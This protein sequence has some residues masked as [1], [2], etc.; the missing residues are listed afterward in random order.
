MTS[1]PYRRPHPPYPPQFKNLADFGQNGMKCGKHEA[2]ALRR[3]SEITREELQSIGMKS[4]WSADWA[5]WY[6]EELAINAD[7]DSARGRIVL[8]RRSAELLGRR[9]VK[10]KTETKLRL[11]NHNEGPIQFYLEPWGRRYVLRPH[12]EFVLVFHGTGVSEPEVQIGPDSVEVWGWS[13][14]TVDVIKNGVEET[15]YVPEDLPAS[16]K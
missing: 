4:E 7:N 1:R 10:A 14:A 2:D 3:A 11:V 15:R 16:I 8:M 5:D 9:V 13:G 12:D 6:E